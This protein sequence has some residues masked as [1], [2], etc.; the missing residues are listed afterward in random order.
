[1]NTIRL[2]GSSFWSRGIARVAAA[3][4][5]GF[6]LVAGAAH[7]DDRT[8]LIGTWHDEQKVQG[9]TLTSDVTFAKDGTFSGFVDNNGRRMWNFAGKWTLTGNAL[10]YDYTKSDFAQIPAGSKDDDV[11]IEIT[12]TTLKLKS[13]SGDQVTTLIRK[14]KG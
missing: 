9:N 12:S 1:M 14:G 3:V 2:P 13:K 7:A 6:L 10:H 5:L 8:A 11:V 4:A